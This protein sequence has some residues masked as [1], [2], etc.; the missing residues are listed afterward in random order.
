MKPLCTFF[1]ATIGLTLATSTGA[2][3]NDPGVK[4]AEGVMGA[5]DGDPA[6]PGIF[7]GIAGPSLPDLLGQIARIPMSVNDYLAASAG[8]IEVMMD[9]KRIVLASLKNDYDVDVH[10]DLVN[11]KLT[12]TF[13]NP[14]DQ[15]TNATYLFPLNQRAAIHR[16]IMR[17]GNEVVEAQ[18]Q[19]ITKAKKTFAKAKSAGKAA[20][21]LEQHRPNMFTQKIANLVPGLPI[22]VTIEYSHTVAKIDG[23]YELV[24]PMVVGPRFQPNKTRAVTATAD[25][26]ASSAS[27]RSVGT[28]AL[29]TLPPQP[30]VA[31]V[32]LPAK[33]LRER[34]SMEI[35]LDAPVAIQAVSSNTHVLEIEDISSTRQRISFAGGRALDNRDFVLRYSLGGPTEDA[36]LMSHWEQDE[37]GYFS[38]MIEPPATL[39]DD[40]I[41]PREMVFLL[42]CSGSMSGLPMAASKRFMREALL[43]LRTTDT[44]R[45]VRFSDHATEFSRT[46]MQATPQNI[47]RGLN[48]TRSLHGSGGT[49][50]TS[51]IRQALS[52]HVPQGTIRNVI[53]LTDGYI[54][55]ELSVLKLVNDELGDSRMMSFGVGT[56][57]NRYLLDELG[58]VGRGFTRYYD[59]SQADESMDAIATEL[60]ARLATP[61]LKDLKIDWDGLPVTDVVPQVLPDLYLGDSVRVTGRFTEPASGTIAIS[62][63][64]NGRRANIRRGVDLGRE[65]ARPA[66]RRLWA[67]DSVAELMHAFITPPQ[68]R[69]DGM[70]NDQLRQAV[71]DIGL[72]FGLATRWTSFVAVSRRVYNKDPEHTTDSDVALPRVAG[73]SASAYGK[74]AMTGYAAPEPGLW[75]GLLVALGVFMTMRR[76]TLVSPGR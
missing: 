9:G 38:L 42:D 7:G 14:L 66:V 48:Y 67:R 25:N 57:V 45:I 21:L 51:G 55:N 33:V 68:L 43:G 61:A 17:V 20:A 10:G 75:L 28:W 30:D 36:G 41:M 24:I 22:R 32:D 15:P 65:R 34:V 35:R 31:G 54:G 40:A 63:V 71:T 8:N 26:H 52:G 39:P 12:Q 50:M 76:K 58:R 4:G 64:G 6:T 60:A 1:I 23:A 70:T 27:A 44:F 37:G 11:V 59:P 73:V 18:I 19:E 56:G 69:L 74:P 29:E 13:E 3:E 46:P 72:D 47:Q 16:M 2:F 53:F 49:V 5:L 62:G